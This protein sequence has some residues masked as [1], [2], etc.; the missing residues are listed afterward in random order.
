M[1]QGIWEAWEVSR[2]LPGARGPVFPKYEPAA[3]N[4]DP[5]HPRNYLISPNFYV[6]D[7]CFFDMFSTHQRILSF[8][9]TNYR[10]FAFFYDP[11]AYLGICLG[12]IIGILHLTTHYMFFDIFIGL[13]IGFLHFQPIVCFLV[14]LL[15]EILDVCIVN[16]LYVFW[17]FCSATYWIIAF[18][19][20]K[21]PPEL[22][23]ASFCLQRSWG[24]SPRRVF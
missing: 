4:S 15:G 9:G 6:P 17:H 10:I 23:R 24:G 13:N 1:F 21:A 22:P 18:F 20:A 7:H 8:V 5:I 2:N 14:F 11:L 16:P 12:Q 3:I 19:S